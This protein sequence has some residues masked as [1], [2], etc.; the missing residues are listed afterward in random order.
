MNRIVV[1]SDGKVYR[2]TYRG[3]HAQEIKELFGT[4]TLATAYLAT[5]E[6][7]RVRQ[8]IARLNPGVMVT[9]EGEC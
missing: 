9:V 2:A 4:D 8:E 5:A 7:E 1:W 6:P 3:A